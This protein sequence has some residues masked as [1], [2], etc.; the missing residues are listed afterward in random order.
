MT[1]STQTATKNNLMTNKRAYKLADYETIKKAI[2]MN[3]WSLF[4]STKEMYY[5]SLCLLKHAA[6]DSLL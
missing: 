2:D 3:R 4:H 6:L 5:L 1:I